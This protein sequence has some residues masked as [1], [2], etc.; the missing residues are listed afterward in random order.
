MDRRIYVLGVILLLCFGLLFFQLNNWQ[1]RQANALQSKSEALRPPV[2]EFEE[3]RGDIVSSD[4]VVLAQSTP[5][6][7]GYG[8][9]RTYPLGALTEDVTGYYDVTQSAA[10]GLEAEYNRYLVVHQSQ[11][12]N[13]QDLLTQ[14]NGTDT[15]VT[16]LSVRLQEV[17]AAALAG[18]NGAVVAIDP[19]NGDVLALY[20][21]PTFN[22]NTLS[23]HDAS[24]V[25]KDFTALQD[26]KD[27]SKSPLINAA[28]QQTYPPGSTM[29]VV[30]TSAMF[31]HD[32]QLTLKTW[33]VL[34]STKLPDTKSVLHNFDSEKCGGNLAKILALSC[35]TAYALIGVKLGARTLSDEATAFGFNKVPPLD[36]PSGEV[37]AATFPA[38]SQLSG[39][40]P[41]YAY[42]AIG[43]FDV[44]ET[45]LQDA[46]VAA[47]IADNGVI[48]AP[49]LLS[50]VVDD[51]GAL[52][53]AY[54]PHKWLT[55][56][57]DTT[58][59][60][61]RTL[62]LGVVQDGTA[63]AVG[64][65]ARLDVAAKTGTAETGAT[66]CSATWL[67]ATA[68]AGPYDVPSI[69]VAAVLPQTAGGC[70]E[71]GAEVAGPVVRQVLDAALENN[72]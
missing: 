12:N 35:D 44:T 27:P 34:S 67:I 29:K 69:A 26:L 31:D 52:V 59:S 48:M 40:P 49:H 42:S 37:D 7:D 25:A 57:S 56:T 50:R 71:T 11:S 41:Y 6:T 4:G 51:D 3:P 32:P 33:P 1:V 8:E 63:S 60:Q 45:A 65:P 64:F 13:L 68:P 16:T 43:Q 21:N 47:G 62:M 61:V 66:G 38:F 36:L 10:T 5:T 53:Y 18:R 23:S 17:A 24:A 70:S 46:L 2:D 14:H 30:T 22:P 58:A 55:A 20:G 9:L 72:G 54:K 28:T 39:N 15:V 19:Q